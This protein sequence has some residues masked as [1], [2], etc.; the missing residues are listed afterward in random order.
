[1]LRHRLGHTDFDY[2]IK[3][4]QENTCCF[5]IVCI[6]FDL[7]LYNPAGRQGTLGTE[8][9]H[10]SCTFTDSEGR[11]VDGNALS[12]GDYTVSFTLSGM[13]SFAVMQ[14]TMS[15][16]AAV[17][18]VNGHS[19]LL[20][21]S[22]PDQLRGLGAAGVLV[23]NGTINFGFIT[24]VDQTATTTAIDAA[25][26]LLLKLQV[27][28]TTEAPVDFA[29]IVTL[30]TDPNQTFIEADYADYADYGTADQDCY[31]LVTAFDGYTATLYPM[32]ADLS[33]ATGHAVTGK[34]L[35]LANT[36]GDL[37]GDTFTVRNCDVVIADE[38]V[39]TTNNDGCFTIPSLPAGEYTATLRYAYG[40]DRTVTFTVA[41]GDLD[42]GNLGMIVCNFDKDTYINSAD[43]AVYYASSGSQSDEADYNKFCDFNH[44]GYV[45]ASDYALYSAFSGCDL[46]L[47]SYE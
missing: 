34:V 21:D 13:Q 9:P 41:D 40:Y 23:Q 47:F 44:D 38:V 22:L 7:N 30:D 4:T 12:A 10:L 14:Y 27:T 36:N 5:L 18:T 29:K 15:Y 17:L 35:A 37:A 43:Y 6:D 2:E 3:Q 28:V 26:Q 39:A 19:D 46:S 1:M 45:N 20:S 24:R 42:L 33:P 25:G 32:T 16:D 11:A 31:A 8:Q